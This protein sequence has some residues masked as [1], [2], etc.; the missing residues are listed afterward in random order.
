[1]NLANRLNRLEKR[2]GPPPQSNRDAIRLGNAFTI[3]ELELLRGR[4]I[5]LER[6]DSFEDTPEMQDL[7][8]RYV[9]VM[10][11]ELRPEKHAQKIAGE[12]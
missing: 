10:E 5:A 12:L 9:A 1:M 2:L 6:R 3:E 4:I 8:R 11:E 7:Y